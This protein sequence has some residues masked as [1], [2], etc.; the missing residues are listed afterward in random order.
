[1]GKLK[2]RGERQTYISRK[3]SAQGS[4]SVAELSRELETSE[5]TIRKDLTDME[6]KVS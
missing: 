6:D 2:S 4:V 1:L 5:V 3:L